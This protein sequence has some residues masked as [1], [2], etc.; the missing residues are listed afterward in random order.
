MRNSKT[1]KVSQFKRKDAILISILTMKEVGLMSLE[2]ISILMG[3][4]TNLIKQVKDFGVQSNINVY[5]D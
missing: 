1:A 4:L 5:Y 2:T 3:N